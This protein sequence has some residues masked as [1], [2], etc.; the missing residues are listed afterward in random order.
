MALNLPN[1]RNVFLPEVPSSIK[2]PAVVQYL[3][4]IKAAVELNFSKTFDNTYSTVSTGA[5]GSFAATGA[6]I[7]VESGIIT[8]IA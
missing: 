2:D 1:P 8:S 4:D 3:K 6:T 5:S 7:T